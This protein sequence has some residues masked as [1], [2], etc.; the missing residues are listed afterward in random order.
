MELAVRSAFHSLPWHS[1]PLSEAPSLQSLPLATAQV[2]AQALGLPFDA[3]RAQYASAVQAGLIERSMLAHRD[4]ENLLGAL[5]RAS[6]GPWAR[7]L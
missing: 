3:L 5:E 2:L 6:L 7:R 1:S 4:F